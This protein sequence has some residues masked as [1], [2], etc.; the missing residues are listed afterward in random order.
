M[1]FDHASHGWIILADTLISLA[2]IAKISETSPTQ[3]N[4]KT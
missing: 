4:A 3:L 2:E 1:L